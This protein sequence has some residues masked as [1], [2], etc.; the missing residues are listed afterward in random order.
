LNSF[1]NT[2]LNRKLVLRTGLALQY[3]SVNLNAYSSRY[4][5][6][7]YRPLA[8]QTSSLLT[9]AYGQIQYK[10]SNQ[11]KTT[12]GLHG[13]YSTLTMT[14]A[15]EPRFSV[16]WDP[17]KRHRLSF[18]YAWQSSELPMRLYY[19][20][21]PNYNEASQ[22]VNYSS[23]ALDYLRNHY[24]TLE[25][26]F[27]L[28]EFWQLK[29]MPYYRSWTSIPVERDSLTGFSLFNYDSE[30]LSDFFPERKLTSEGTAL[31]YG[32]D[33]SIHKQFHQGFYV[34][35]NVSWLNAKYK[36]SDKISHSTR[37]D[38]QYITR[39][40][41]GKEFKIGKAKNNVFFLSSTL[42]YAHGGYVTPLDLESSSQLQDEVFSDNWYAK[43]LPNYF[44]WD[45][46]AGMRLNSK[47]RQLNHYFYLDMMNV[48]NTAN[49]ARYYY[50]GKERREA[51]IY[52]IGLLPDI[53]YRIQF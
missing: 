43:E 24:T 17:H 23:T 6:F 16:T 29:V 47:N 45:V 1:V 35:A 32:I 38:R 48:L 37:F 13:Q 31:N 52:Q 39:L 15:I 14:A 18:G 33:F 51:A 22:V 20:R 27:K 50:N 34:V 46:K 30:E 25:Y 36:G 8:I 19:H 11:L 44:R 42:T 10:F 9:E 40:M 21:Y 49:V 5:T 2:R 53:L 3:R 26:Q 4:D 7:S 12:L 28:S 41:G